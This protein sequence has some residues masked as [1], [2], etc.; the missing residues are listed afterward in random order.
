MFDAHKSSP[1]PLFKLL[2]L[3]VGLYGGTLAPGGVARAT[4]DVTTPVV[5]P[6]EQ[7]S[8]AADKLAEARASAS[9]DD[10]PASITAYLEAFEL[11]PSLVPQYAQELGHQYNWN[12]EPHEAISWFE[13]RLEVVP[14][15]VDARMGY[16]RALSWDNQTYKG[17]QEWRRV[18]VG[19]PRILEA[20]LGEAQTRNWLGR[21]REAARRYQ[22]IL[23]DHPD[24]KAAR[25]GMAQAWA[26]AGEMELAMEALDPLR[27]DPEAEALRESILSSWRPQ[28]VA[29]SGIIDDSDELQILD[30]SL[31]WESTN[32]K[33]QDMRVGLLQTN[34]WQ[35][36]QP[37]IGAWGLNAGAGF[38]PGVA[39]QVHG[40]LTGQQFSS[41][42]PVVNG[43]AEDV[44]WFLLGWD[45]WFTWWPHHQWRFDLSTDRGYVNTPIAI[46]NNIAISSVS[47]SADWRINPNL[48]WSTAL[49]YSHYSDE[50]NRALATTNLALSRGN[51]WR[52]RLVPSLTTF[53]YSKVSNSGYWNP[54]EFL[55]A[56]L[57]GGVSR[58]SQPARSRSKR[59][60]GPGT[61]GRTRTTTASGTGAR[62]CAG[63]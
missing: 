49:R 12:D 11:D 10:H 6:P 58:R 40:Y 36:Q 37:Y 25:L 45:A 54:N 26:W 50:N 4:S 29:R 44:D 60:S 9:R 57:S 35:D 20:R 28:L 52:W 34:F 63:E 47:A 43:A 2:V 24:N 56:T 23:D 33:W 48:A 31:A 5:A 30:N 41:N 17:W 53:S 16:A 14:G 22:G 39:T 7:V 55:N 15:N 42:S 27:G 8:L 21:H 18:L 51:R 38:R 62:G 59:N 46:S 61:S 13:K 1:L 19:H 3:V 32:A